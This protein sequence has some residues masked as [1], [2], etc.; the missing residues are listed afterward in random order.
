MKKL[1]FTLLS[2]SL[3]T[4]IAY[5]KAPKKLAR[6]EPHEEGT[7]PSDRHEVS[8]LKAEIDMKERELNRLTKELHELK[9]KHAKAEAIAENYQKSTINKTLEEHPIHSGE[10]HKM[11]RSDRLDRSFGRSYVY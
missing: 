10:R 8:R 1:T 3:L 6:P 11:P 7:M 9:V 2:L 5:A 4:S